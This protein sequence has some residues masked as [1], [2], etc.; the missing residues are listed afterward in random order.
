MWSIIISKL[1]DSSS[2][3]WSVVSSSLRPHG[4][5]CQAPV[6]MEFSRQEYCSGLV[7]SPGDLPDPGIKPGSLLHRRQILYRWSHQ[8]SLSNDSPLCVCLV[9]QS[10]LTLWDP[11]D[12]SLPVFSV[13]GIILAGILEWV[14][15]FFSRGSSQPRDWTCISCIGR[16]ILYHCVTGKTFLCF[17]ILLQ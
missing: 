1:W 8:G 7:P 16:Q 17:L 15:I 3:S 13:H 4:L 10:C 5:A 9:A 11:M 12:C 14:A 2:G 6:A